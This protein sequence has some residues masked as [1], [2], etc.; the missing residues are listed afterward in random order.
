MNID[1]YEDF[2]NNHK[3][4]LGDY[5]RLVN[6]DDNQVKYFSNSTRP[7]RY[8]RSLNPASMELTKEE[9]ISTIFKIID[10]DVSDTSYFIDS[11]DEDVYGWV[12]P[13]E[14][15]KLEDYE[16]SAMKYNL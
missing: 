1:K 5:V 14:I 12:Q 13:D 16:A 6:V 11:L 8:H 2:R 7:P 3:F 4:Q 9:L 15:E 10:I